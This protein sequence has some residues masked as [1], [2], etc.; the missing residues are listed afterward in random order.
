VKL[1]DSVLQRR[2]GRG[3]ANGASAPAGQAANGSSPG[4]PTALPASPSAS[5]HR[6][7]GTPASTSSADRA[8]LAKRERLVERFTAMQ[9]DL[10]GVF[11]EMVIRDHVAMDIL[12]RK[13]A[14]LQ[15]VDAELRQIEQM[16][17]AGATGVDRCPVCRALYTRGASFCW[18]CGSS[19]AATPTPT[20]SPPEGSA[21]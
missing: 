6:S 10:G 12:T 1:L 20:P 13:A 2:H 17:D 8:L 4:T 18:Q 15:R 19:L 14:E 21:A 11:Y 3:Q 7:A 5:G 16:L 9:L